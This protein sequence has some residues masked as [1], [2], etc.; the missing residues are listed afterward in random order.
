MPGMPVAPHMLGSVPLCNNNQM[1]LGEVIGSLPMDDATQN[2]FLQIEM[3]RVGSP[4]SHF[5]EEPQ[6]TQHHVSEHQQEATPVVSLAGH[7]SS[8]RL[9]TLSFKS[10]GSL[11]FM[12]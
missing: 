9:N 11:R 4:P 10:M 8:L 12:F 7:L 5:T 2:G 3:V 1:P 6:N